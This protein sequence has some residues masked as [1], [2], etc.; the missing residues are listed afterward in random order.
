MPIKKMRTARW[1]APNSEL[2]RQYLCKGQ[3]DLPFKIFSSLAVS[4]HLICIKPRASAEETAIGSRPLD[5]RHGSDKGRVKSIPL[6]RLLET[7]AIRNRRLSLPLIL[8]GRR[9]KEKTYNEIWGFHP[10]LVALCIG[11]W[12]EYNSEKKCRN[13][14]TTTTTKLSFFLNYC[15]IYIFKLASFLLTE[16]QTNF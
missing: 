16:V 11:R 2:P 10:R 8:N 9:T 3:K 15:F 1:A 6:C 5:A 13:A 14:D 4:G 12:S 7:L